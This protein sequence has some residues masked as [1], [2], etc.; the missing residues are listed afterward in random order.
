MESPLCTNP[1]LFLP[2]D[3]GSLPDVFPADEDNDMESWSDDEPTPHLDSALCLI[4]DNPHH[5]IRHTHAGPPR[6]SDT[7]SHTCVIFNQNV[8]SLEFRDDKLE[9]II[10][11]IIDSIIHSYCL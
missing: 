11:M 8:N 10:E 4:P 2:D 7:C 9:R 3:S 5:S 1:L 6:L